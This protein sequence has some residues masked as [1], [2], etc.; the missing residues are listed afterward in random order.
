VSEYVSAYG[1]IVP[2]LNQRLRNS[3]IPASNGG[4][5]IVSGYLEKRETES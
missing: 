4:I 2:N 3:H 1:A 5:A